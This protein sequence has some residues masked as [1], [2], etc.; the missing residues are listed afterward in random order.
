[1]GKKSKKTIGR[2]ARDTVPLRGGELDEE[3]EWGWGRC[4]IPR[5]VRAKLAANYRWPEGLN[6]NLHH[7]HNTVKKFR[8]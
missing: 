3:G 4:P 7:H 1:M 8:A 6:Y 5:S 2:N